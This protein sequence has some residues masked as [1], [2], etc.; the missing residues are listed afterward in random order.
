VKPFEAG[1]VAAGAAYLLVL[2]WAMQNLS[3]DIWGALVIVPVLV[4]LS[5][6]ADQPGHFPTT[7]NTSA[8]GSGRDSA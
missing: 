2:G 4:A 7:S 8:R 3:Y 1:V 5:A 6:P